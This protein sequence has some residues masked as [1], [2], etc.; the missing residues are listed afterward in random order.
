MAARMLCAYYDK[1]CDS[2][3]LFR[4][5]KVEQ[6]PSFGTYLNKYHVLYLDKSTGER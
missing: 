2:R 5:L 4:G 3:E 6:D 1:S